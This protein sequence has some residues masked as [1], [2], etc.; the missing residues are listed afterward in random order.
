MQPALHFLLLKGYTTGEAQKIRQS[1][2]KPV[3]LPFRLQRENIS[4]LSFN[5]RMFHIPPAKREDSACGIFIMNF[6]ILLLKMFRLT[7]S[8][9]WLIH[10]FADSKLQL[11]GGYR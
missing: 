4:M 6:F 5:K 3:G 2:R 8:Q 1:D 9:E 11:A 10:I 7:W